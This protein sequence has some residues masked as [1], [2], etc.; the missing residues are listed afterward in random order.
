MI[1]GDRSA[2]FNVPLVELGNPAYAG[3]AILVHLHEVF[4]AVEVGGH[5]R[6]FFV[7]CLLADGV[8]L[9][10]VVDATNFQVVGAIGS[11]GEQGKEGQEEHN[12]LHFD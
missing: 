1:M 5:I 9:V 3:P 4:H 6:A 12:E 8:G 7:G 11:R 10:D 2:S